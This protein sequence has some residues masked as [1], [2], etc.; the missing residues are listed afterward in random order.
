MTIKEL[1]S[2]LQKYDENQRVVVTN[3]DTGDSYEP[4]VE[5]DDP[6]VMIVFDAEY[7]AD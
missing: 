7:P 2:K 3:S 5:H 6:D 4:T 1:I